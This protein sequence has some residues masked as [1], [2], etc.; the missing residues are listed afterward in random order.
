MNDYLD[1]S[2]LSE[3]STGNNVKI[4]QEKLKIL[5]FY[6]GP[7][8]GSFGSTLKNATERYQY[9]NRLEVNGIIDEKTWDLL[10]KQTPSPFDEERQD[11]PTLSLGDRGEDVKD[12]Q[13]KLTTLMYYEGPIN[14]VFDT[15]TENAVKKLQ[16]INKLTADGIVGKNTWNALTFLYAPLA[17]CGGESTPPSTE[18]YT[19]K[20]GDTIFMGNN[21]LN[22]VFLYKSL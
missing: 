17:I 14:G 21:W 11:K 2:T 20:S 22:I 13:T 18:S 12:L 16:L 7:I 8:T 15:K 1:F 19:V 4:A 6:N 10:F 5:G 3:G 9:Y